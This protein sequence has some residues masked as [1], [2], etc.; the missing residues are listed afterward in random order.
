MSRNPDRQTEFR[1][2]RFTV[3]NRKS[4][5]KISTDGVLLGA[6]CSAIA[7]GTALDIGCG[8][9]LI[10]LMVA[11]R[12]M[13]EITAVEIDALA[14]SEARD[15]FAISPWSGRFSLIEDDFIRADLGD[16]KY[17]LIVSNPP[18]F[19]NGVVST[20]RARAMARH[21]SSLT[22]S[23]LIAKASNLLST[24]GRLAMISPADRSSEIEFQAAMS[25]L[26]LLRR[27]D[28]ST[29]AGRPPSRTLWEFGRHNSAPMLSYMSIRL[30]DD[31][32]S[33]EYRRLTQDFYLNF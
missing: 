8:T 2:K 23:S 26:N 13:S 3:C 6:W 14:A 27:T 12:D 32:F 20:D 18:Y 22:Y 9:G 16:R 4:A 33:D 31:D 25:H 17:D 21:E 1:F 7:G 5:M 10:A 24:G 19:S 30:H 28:V 11:Q 15:N 29:V